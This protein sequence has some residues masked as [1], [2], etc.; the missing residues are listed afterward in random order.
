MPDLDT[1]PQVYPDLGSRQLKGQEEQEVVEEE[2]LQTLELVR[3]NNVKTLCR[4]LFNIF[5]PHEHDIYFAFEIQIQNR[6]S[7]SLHCANRKTNLEQEAT[8][9]YVDL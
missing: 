3:H 8:F 6:I 7:R 4:F 9:C 5:V 1:A 2:T